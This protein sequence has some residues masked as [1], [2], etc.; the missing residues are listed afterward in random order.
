MLWQ[1]IADFEPR[2]LGTYELMKARRAL[3]IP[4][5]STQ[6]NVELVDVYLEIYEKCRSAVVT[7]YAVCPV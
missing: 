4:I 2:S 3:D 1:T 6:G 7:E 5:D